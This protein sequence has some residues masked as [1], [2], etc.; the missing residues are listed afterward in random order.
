MQNEMRKMPGYYRIPIWAG[1]LSI[2][3]HT[4]ELGVM[5]ARPELLSGWVKWVQVSGFMLT[6][7]LFGG[8]IY[9]FTKERQSVAVWV[10]A[11]GHG[12]LIAATSFAYVHKAGWEW[13]QPT[14]M[15]V[16][17]AG[18]I[19]YL[20]A[21]FSDVEQTYAPGGTAGSEWQTW[22]Q[23]VCDVVNQNDREVRAA[24]AASEAMLRQAIDT[25]AT[26]KDAHETFVGQAEDRLKKLVDSEIATFAEAVEDAAK[27]KG[28]ALAKAAQRAKG[29]P[30]PAA[31]E[32][33]SKLG[34]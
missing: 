5:V 14:A 13:V 23:Q 27:R 19:P 6:A 21:C 17:F 7:I 28:W 2:A 8:A 3:I 20:L 29:E 34:E 31:I 4:V 24:L 1:M 32:N 33:D 10:S 25:I 11:A 18:L 15:L 30:G 12:L 16:I 9:V 26:L 22:R